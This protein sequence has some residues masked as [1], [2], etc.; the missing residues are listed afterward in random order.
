MKKFIIISI[1]TMLTASIS[2]FAGGNSD[3]TKAATKYPIILVHGI[4]T[5]VD[6]I[7]SHLKVKEALEDKGAEVYRSW[8]DAF[9]G[10]FSKGE[11]FKAEVLRIL[12]ISGAQKVHLI[13]HSNGVV[14]ARYAVS[15]LGIRDKIASMTLLCGPN[16]GTSIA[17][18]GMGLIPDALEPAVS[19]VFRWLK[20]ADVNGDFAQNGYD[21]TRPYMQNVFNPNTPDASGVYYQSWAVKIKYPKFNNILELS[22]A[23]ILPFDGANDGLIPEYSAKWTNFQTTITGSFWGSGIKHTDI[24]S[25]E[26]TNSFDSSEFYVNIAIGLK[27]RNM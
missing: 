6:T 1:V 11:Q 2:L 25:G 22:W 24:N 13:A 8:V 23:I 12:A 7:T 21:L 26:V 17:D 16:K 4:S 5:N 27:D 3:T 14:Y 15:N 9:S 20:P 10:T 19:Q 18:I